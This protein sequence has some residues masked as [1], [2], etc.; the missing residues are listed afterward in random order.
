MIAEL[1]NRRGLEHSV[2]ID[3]KLAMGQGV[4]IA[5]DQEEIGTTFHW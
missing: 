4:N 1:N 2:L 3:Y 5:L